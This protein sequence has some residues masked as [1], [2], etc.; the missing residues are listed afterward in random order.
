M[1]RKSTLL[2]TVKD[3]ITDLELD[4]SKIN[5]EFYV[6]LKEELDTLTDS[7][8]QPNTRH[9]FS[10]VITI[11][12]FGVIANK[13]NWLEIEDFANAR[14]RQLKKYL[15]LPNG[16]PSS[17]TIKRCVGILKPEELEKIMYKVINDIMNKFYRKIDT[18]SYLN[19][20][21]YIED[22]I[23]MDGKAERGSGRKS[24]KDGEVSKLQLLNVYST[25][26][27]LCLISKEIDKKTN[28]IPVGQEIIKGLDLKG[29]ILT[30]DAL[31]TQ[32]ELTK[33]VIKE[34]N[35]N[36]CFPIKD[37]QTDFYND[38]ILYFNDEN[39]LNDCRN[40]I[41][42]NSHKFSFCHTIDKNESSIIKREYYSSNEINWYSKLHDWTGIK[43]F[44][45]EKTITTSLINGEETITYRYFIASFYDVNLF[46]KASRQHW[47]VENNCHWHMDYTFNSDDNLT[48]NKQ[49]AKGLITIKHFAL[50]LIQIV[51]PFY[52]KHVSLSRV[53]GMIEMDPNGLDKMFKHLS[54][55]NHIL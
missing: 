7:R 35:G 55:A 21:F 53:R 31:N 9:I 47:R 33:I 23:A 37:N 1:A 5:D 8:Y 38:L 29:K 36:Y 25:E 27:G 30:V 22:I 14:K 18:N 49:S 45:M 41:E 16:I 11:A 43:S 51:Q 4:T 3:G 50:A 6:F 32:K 40:N 15:S 12:L 26:Y 17:Y 2:E 54:K 48:V 52:G 34:S 46:A 19:D 42:K 28:E 39:L 20:D 24:S 10:E 44:N 13:D